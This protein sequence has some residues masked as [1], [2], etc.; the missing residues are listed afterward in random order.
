MVRK[1]RGVKMRR[2]REPVRMQVLVPGH[3]PVEVLAYCADDARF[4]AMG[5]VDVPMEELMK[6][7]VAVHRSA[8]GLEVQ[9]AGDS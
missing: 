1:C 8:A 3:E 9:E 6:C 4:Q 5:A 7:K 2:Y